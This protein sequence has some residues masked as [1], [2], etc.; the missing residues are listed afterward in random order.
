MA[1]LGIDLGTTNSLIGV[2]REGEAQLIPN[3]LGSVLTPSIVGLDDDGNILVGEEAKDRLITHP[4]QTVAT[5]KRLM[6]TKGEVRLGKRTFRPEEL[7][8]LVLRSLKRDAEQFLGEPVEEAVISVP[9]YFNN[10]QRKATRVAGQLAGL[11]VERLI[12]EP[13]AAALAYGLT[14][15]EDCTI[16]VFDLG[17]GTLDVSILEVFDGVM[18]VHASSGDNRLGG[19]DFRFSILGSLGRRHGFDPASV[20]GRDRQALLNLAERMKIDLTQGQEASYAFECSGGS[21]QGVMTRAEFEE[22]AEA[23]FRRMRVPVERAIRDARLSPDAIDHVVLAGGA[24]R[25]PSVRSLVGRLLGKLPLSHLDPDSLIAMGATLQGARKE[26]NEAVSDVIVTDVCPF[27]LGTKVCSQIRGM[28]HENVILPIIERNATIP[29]SRSSDLVPHHPKQTK[30]QIEVYQGEGLR[31]DQNVLLGGMEI[32]LPRPPGNQEGLR[33]RY[34]YDVNGLLEVEVY[35]KATG[36]TKR[37][38]IDSFGT[39]LSEEEIAKRFAALAEVKL[40]PWDQTPNRVLIHRAERLYEELLG[41]AREQLV[42]ALAT[43]RV[44]IDRQSARH[45]EEVREQFAAY[46]NGFGID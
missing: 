33:L 46:L 19:E 3:A 35:I 27:T 18:E 12:N 13:T 7:S 42:H 21:G 34:T 30:V 17:G 45:V 4:D 40:P 5:F 32:S 10:H 22:D 37:Q 8:S 15:E 25:M 26:R 9:A 31:P 11:K 16:L 36:E 39:E 2:W 20:R 28:E 41:E 38:V 43:F 14:Q 44:E 29:I 1:V 6:G 23:L 24:T